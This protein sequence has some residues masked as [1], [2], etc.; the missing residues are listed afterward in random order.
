MLLICLGAVMT[1][2][3]STD[4]LFTTIGATPRR[5]VTHRLAQAAYAVFG[6]LPDGAMRHA[7]VGPVIMSLVAIWWVVGICLG[8]GMIF[9]GF[10]D[11]VR[12]S[13]S[14]EPVGFT[15]ALSHAGHL[16]STLG[17]G[18]TEAS[19]VPY[20]L[21]GVACAVNGMVVLTLSVS[22][23]LSTT[24]TVTQGRGLL[25]LRE[26]IG[27]DDP[28]WR[29][30]VLPA[31]ATLVAQLNTAPLA[32]YYSHPEPRLRLPRQLAKRFADDPEALR[33]LRDLPGGGDLDTWAAQYRLSK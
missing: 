23:V 15:G 4:F 13:A 1:F 18:I 7:S 3:V 6:K 26:T 24:Q 28:E 29:S 27:P 14:G 8:W 19:S 20:A 9:A 25:L 22:F 30:T 32:L 11:G 12:L 10:S 5:F 2:Y 16:L 31:L 17:G 21:L 33:I